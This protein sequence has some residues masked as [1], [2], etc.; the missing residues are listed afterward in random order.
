MILQKI[1]YFFNIHVQ[2]NILLVTFSAMM[3]KLYHSHI[4]VSLFGSLKLHRIRAT[5]WAFVDIFKGIVRK[6]IH[7]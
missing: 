4:H 7:I 1:R 5:Q 3:P 2:K 6:K